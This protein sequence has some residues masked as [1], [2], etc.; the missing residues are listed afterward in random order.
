MIGADDPVQCLAEERETRRGQEGQPQLH[1]R[2]ERGGW[3][4]PG[5]G[6][7]P[8]GRVVFEERAG[9]RVERP[10]ELSLVVCPAFIAFVGLDAGGHVQ[11]DRHQ[12]GPHRERGRG[13]GLF[14]EPADA[15]RW[16][17]G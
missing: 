11:E 3:D 16:L 5:P 6:N 9:E 4:R 12:A 10:G 14:A 15:M 1:E 2:L 8:R 17:A 7:G 13:L